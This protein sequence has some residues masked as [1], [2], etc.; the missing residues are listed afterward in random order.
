MSVQVNP[1][2]ELE[3]GFLFQYIV[4]VGSS[5]FKTIPNKNLSDFNTSYVS[6]QDIGTTIFV[7][8]FKFQYIVCV[9]SSLEQAKF[10]QGALIF[11]YIVCVG[12]SK[13]SKDEVT[14]FILFQYIV[15][16]G[17]RCYIPYHH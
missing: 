3:V 16:V 13:L 17:S 4:C 10:G 5:R 11:Q 14:A 1:K 7:I 8:P 15:C 12:S 9:G 6:V 2:L